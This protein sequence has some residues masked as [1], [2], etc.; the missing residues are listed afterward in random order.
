MS[1]YENTE[2]LKDDLVSMSIRDI[3]EVIYSHWQHPWYGAEPY[4]EGMRLSDDKGNFG[5]DDWQTLA[6]YFLGNAA[7]WRG[8]IARTVKAELKRRLKSEGM[9][10]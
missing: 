3:G 2:L 1:T 8:P 9:I 5:A 10:K 6:I 4:I 7:R